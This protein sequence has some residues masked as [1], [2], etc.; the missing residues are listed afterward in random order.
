[1]DKDQLGQFFG[2]WKFMAWCDQ[3]RWKSESGDWGSLGWDREEMET[4]AKALS[5]AE[6]PTYS[7]L[8][9]AHWLTYIFDY[10]FP[11]EKVW[12]RCLPITIKVAH[13]FQSERKDI[14]Q[15]RKDATKREVDKKT[16]KTRESLVI[17]GTP[18]KFSHFP[19][20]THPRVWR[21]LHLLDKLDVGRDFV[22]FLLSQTEGEDWVR[23][24]AWALNTLTYSKENEEK[25]LELLRNR[26]IP[27]QLGDEVLGYPKRLWAAL[28]DYV[29]PWRW[30][31]EVVKRAINE[32]RSEY[33]EAVR[34]WEKSEN[35]L[36]QLELPGDQWNEEFF[37]R[38][39]LLRELKKQERCKGRAARVLLRR[40]FSKYQKELRGC[41]PEQFDVTF[42]FRCSLWTCF[43]C[44]LLKEGTW[45]KY[46]FKKEGEPC[47]VLKLLLG[48]DVRCE[49]K[50]CYL[51]SSKPL[52]IC[53]GIWVR[54]DPAPS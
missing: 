46:C 8:V 29:K 27:Q 23:R 6:P 50:T 12:G 17:R 5:L 31:D 35:Y 42:N 20:N 41:Y 10:M 14:D 34:L 33:P 18:L 7:E 15:I 3:M 32:H 36:D 44:P 11:G 37:E 30:R 19:E 16:K 49:P 40:L 52:P 24:V 28:R 21:T 54:G 2:L 13:D 38:V 26:R 53:D 45:K 43:A 4:V 47:K 1:M 39:K 22:R 51:L 48:Y 25:A 9:L